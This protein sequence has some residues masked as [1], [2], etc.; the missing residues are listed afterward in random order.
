[1]SPKTAQKSKL[2][3][4]K[5][6]A[7]K[8]AK[9]QRVDWEC[10]YNELYGGRQTRNGSKELLNPQQELSMH[11]FEK[12]GQCKAWRGRDPADIVR[13]AQKGEESQI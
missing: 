2:A 3:K 6:A 10:I 5:K 9:V 4:V 7:V 12:L 1:M 11:C 13:E 8:V